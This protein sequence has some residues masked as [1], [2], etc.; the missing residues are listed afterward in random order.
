MGIVCL[1]IHLDT[2]PQTD[3]LTDLGLLKTLRFPLE[4]LCKFEQSLAYSLQGL[5]H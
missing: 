4:C 1:L 2:F 5:I 3:G